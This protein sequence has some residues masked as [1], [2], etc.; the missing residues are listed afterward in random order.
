[1][2]G[3]LTGLIGVA[4]SLGWFTQAKWCQEVVDAHNK[5]KAMLGDKYPEYNRKYHL[6]R[7]SEVHSAWRKFQYALPW[8]KAATASAYQA[9]VR[10]W[11]NAL[12]SAAEAYKEELEKEAAKAAKEVA[13]E[14]VPTWQKYLPYALI[15]GVLALGLKG[16]E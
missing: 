11:A 15:L 13:V 1:M 2:I 5:L 3:I 12:Q 9:K 10:D 4:K 7:Y 8:D 14:A 16:G 6:D